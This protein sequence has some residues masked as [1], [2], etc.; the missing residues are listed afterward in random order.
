MDSNTHTTTDASSID[1]E[2]IEQAIINAL[3][4]N[5]NN[6]S[7]DSVSEIDDSVEFA[8]GTD[9]KLYTVETTVAPS[10]SAQQTTAI[11]LDIRNLVLLFFL[12]YVTFTFY[13]MIKTTINSFMGG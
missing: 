1:Y 7:I 13:R 11:L 10:T 12:T 8:S 2:Q 6:D 5:N 9:A 3:E 4:E